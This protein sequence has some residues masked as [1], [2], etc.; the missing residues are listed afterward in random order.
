MEPVTEDV[1]EIDSDSEPEPE[2]ELI[3]V[4]SPKPEQSESKQPD[5]IN[6]CPECPKEYNDLGLITNAEDLYIHNQLWHNLDYSPEICQICQF[7]AMN[8]TVFDKI[9]NRVSVYFLA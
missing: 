9:H 3:T 1:I 8:K 2:L 7:R 4:D 6:G 5:I